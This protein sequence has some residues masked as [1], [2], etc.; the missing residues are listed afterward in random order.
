MRFL[1]F[2][3]LLVLPAI[4]ALPTS[5][6]NAKSERSL[7]SKFTSYFKSEPAAALLTLTEE[8][9]Y[10]YDDV[11]DFD[12]SSDAL[13]AE[14][15]Y[16]VAKSKGGVKT[17]SKYP[18]CGSKKEDRSGFARYTG[19]RLIGDDLSGA[20]PV[21]P[22]S[23]CINLCNAYGNSCGGI[24]FDDDAYRC[25]LKGIKYEKWEFVETGNEDDVLNLVGGCAAWGEIV[26]EEMDEVCCRD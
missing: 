23:N 14:E 18:L 21:S 16:Y 2:T 20:V 12:P 17:A 13:V 15:A 24:Y 6:P 11:E 3:L 7:L 4:L 10:D 1:I 25:W 5:Q 9:E 8:V 26:P 22:R 19:W